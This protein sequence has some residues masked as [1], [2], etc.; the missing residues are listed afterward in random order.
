MKRMN[1]F[2][3]SFPKPR[4][5]GKCQ[6]SAL[7]DGRHGMH[8]RWIVVMRPARRCVDNMEDGWWRAR[9]GVCW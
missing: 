8:G 6:A 4:I 3:C 1:C 7:D 5:L 2:S 9:A